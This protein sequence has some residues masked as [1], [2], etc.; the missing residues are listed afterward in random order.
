MTVAAGPTP[1]RLRGRV[2]WSLAGNV[3]GSLS[4]VATAIL[5][6]R[7][8]G[9]DVFGRFALLLSAQVVLVTFVSS[10]VGQIATKLVAE[11]QHTDPVRLGVVIATLSDATWFAMITIAAALLLFPAAFSGTIFG[12]D[13]D[14]SLVRLVVPCL[15]FAALAALQQGLLQGFG[16]FDSLIFIN[17]LRLLSGLAALALLTPRW[18]LAGAI[19]S[20]GIAASVTWLASAW[21]L[22]RLPVARRASGAHREW[23]ILTKLALPSWLSGM[24]FVL[25]A[26]AGNL[27]LSR[28]PNGL[29]AVGLFAAASQLGRSVLL[30]LPGALTAPFLAEMSAAMGRGDLPRVRHLF[31]RSVMLTSG[32]ALG[33]A[34]V[35]AFFGPSLLLLYGAEFVLAHKTLLV[36]LAS[37][38]LA[39]LTLSVNTSLL[40]QGRAWTIVNVTVI[41]MLVFL[42]T[43]WLLPIGGALGL[44]FAYLFAYG[45]QVVVTIPLLG[46]A[47]RP[48]R[49]A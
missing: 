10:S 16:A 19:I 3:L 36:I 44:A 47:M 35:V 5:A 24:A 28:Q 37:T 17:G 20:V 23:S 33:P 45:L 13:S 48:A 30:F 25:A 43:L 4:V 40:A 2:L 38:V 22:H 26:W 18:G 7:W 12:P 11:L 46:Q 31:G 9:S 42:A 1:A 8:L 14:A 41:W 27:V 34:I 29:V 32:S 49:L 6:A 21:V 39:A 15:V